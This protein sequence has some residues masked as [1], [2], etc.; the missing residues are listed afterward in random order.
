MNTNRLR[1][2]LQFAAALTLPTL[3]TANFALAEV[4]ASSVNAIVA[5]VDGN[6]I[7][8]RDISKRLPVSRQIRPEDAVNDPAVRAILDSLIMENIILS[9]AES[10]KISAGNE[11]VDQ[12]I[13]EVAKRNNLTRSGFE[14]AL[15]AEGRS[16][17]DYKRFIKVDILKSRL[18]GSVIQ[19]AAPVSDA[20][21]DEFIQA[22]PQ[23]KGQETYVRLA[24]ILVKAAPVR[25]ET[26]AESRIKKALEELKAGQSFEQVARLYSDAPESAD[27]GLL[28]EIAEKDLQ[29]DI[30]DAVLK[31]DTKEH[32]EIISSGGQF[33]ILQV[34]ERSRGKETTTVHAQAREEAKEFLT[35]QKQEARMQAFFTTE[36]L[37]SHT[38]DRKL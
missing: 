28:G 37:K 20:E 15:I 14:Q 12:Y 17:E 35:R 10:R 34:I 5:S 33:Q 1:S 31:L 24:R 38:V 6:P 36:L 13:D 7:T 32:S 21:V 11:E 4:Q 30:F 19:N 3:L 22:Q 18:A 23:Q 26:E 2:F 8:L 29:G 25:S 27:G 16:L 9:E